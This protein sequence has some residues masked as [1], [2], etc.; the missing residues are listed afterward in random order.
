MQAAT[1]AT[2]PTDSQPA[3][4]FLNQWVRTSDDSSFR[5]LFSVSPEVIVDTLASR[6]ILSDD[7]AEA[8]FIVYCH[9]RCI[10]SLSH[11][12]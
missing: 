10:F 11:P 12:A 9:C 6:V 8:M 5:D 3:R 1:G 2:H 7:G 4:I